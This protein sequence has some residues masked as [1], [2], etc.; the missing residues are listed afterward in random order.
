MISSLGIH[1]LI[2]MYGVA[3]QPLADPILLR[4]LLV[5]SVDSAGLHPVSEP[6]IVP[7]TERGKGVT[8]VILLS[9]SH[10]AFHS[11]PELS[12][13][14]LDVFTCGDAKPEIVLDAFAKALKP[15]HFRTTT[16]FRGE[17]IFS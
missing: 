4:N 2:D 15:T 14:V 12:M 11:Y 16:V 8:G 10:I 1:L 5:E 6:I 3:D 9:E 7:F 13:L 17:D